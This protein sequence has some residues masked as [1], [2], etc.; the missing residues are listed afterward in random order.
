MKYLLT[1]ITA[2]L[3]VFFNM[4]N[5]DASTEENNE[6][7][8]SII[9][10]FKKDIT[11]DGHNEIIELKGNLLSEGTNYY[12]NLWVNIRSEYKNLDWDIAY[13]GGY[14][15]TLKIIHLD[16]SDSS[17]LLF[18]SK[19]HIEDKKSNYHLHTFKN[20][21]IEQI[22]L[23][24]QWHVNGEYKEGFF[25]ELSLAHDKKPIEID[26]HHLKEK[27]ISDG[28]YNKDGKLLKPQKLIIEP[29]IKIEPLTIN[30]SKESNLESTHEVRGTNEELLGTIKTLWLY[31]NNKWIIIKTSW[32][33]K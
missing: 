23:P 10:T 27:Y 17:E 5:S 25:A 15:P 6:R 4:T 14:E 11:G 22:E 2:I 16:N 30:N 28:S 9:Q 20:N 24:E 26:M 32:L 13:G 29:N 1:L 18:Q 8:S 12:H 21:K 31:E 19:H 3:I 33:A 7:G